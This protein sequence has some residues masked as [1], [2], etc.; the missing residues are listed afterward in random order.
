MIYVTLMKGRP[1]VKQVGPA[2]LLLAV[3]RFL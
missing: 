2:C 1:A 3:S